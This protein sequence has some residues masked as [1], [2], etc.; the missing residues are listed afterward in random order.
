MSS[1]VGVLYV[2][3]TPIGNLSDITQRAID[4]LKEVAI[5]AA[6]DTRTSKKLL[7][8]LG[9]K[10][11]LIAYH[12][13]NEQQQLS[14]I[15]AYLDRG[16]SVALVS[17]AG[18][19]LISDPGYPLISYLLRHDYRV[20]PI[21]G[22]SALITALSVSGIATDRFSFEG[23]LPAKSSARIKQLERL[24]SET[25]TMVIFES[26]HRIQHTL[27]DMSDVFGGERLVTV[28]RELTKKFETIQQDNLATLCSWIEQ[29]NQQKGEFVLVVSGADKQKAYDSDSGREIL[30]V[31]LQYLGPSQAAAAAAQIT[32]QKKKH[33]YELA[34]ELKEEN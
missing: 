34:L 24:K 22:V 16:E 4:T 31:L 13:H 33:M 8:L 20:I 15:T 23:F 3:S 14:A 21:P 17:D 28:C 30:L 19:P 10:Q 12:E 26:C 11:S 32:G 18:T 2:V 5:V 27:N 7:N 29:S 25:R 9:I 6:E 1:N